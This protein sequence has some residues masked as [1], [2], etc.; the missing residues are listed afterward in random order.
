MNVNARNLI[1]LRLPE[2]S[3]QFVRLQTIEF[4]GLLALADESF[5]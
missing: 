5:Q 4:F 1:G 2:N 3:L